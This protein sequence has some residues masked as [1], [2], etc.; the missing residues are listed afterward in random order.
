MRITADTIDYNIV[1][2]IKNLILADS[3][4]TEFAAY[5]HGYI[6]GMIA[7]RDRLKEVLKC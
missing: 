3:F 6:D 5:S 7:L 2:E 4:D 1:E